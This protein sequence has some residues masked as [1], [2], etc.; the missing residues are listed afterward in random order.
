MLTL[1]H[2]FEPGATAST[3]GTSFMITDLV[4]DGITADANGTSKPYV[5][6]FNQVSDSTS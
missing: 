2:S 5:L 1:L 3:I 6:G 4:N